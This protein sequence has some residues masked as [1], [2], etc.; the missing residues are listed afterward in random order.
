MSIWLNSGLRLV[1]LLSVLCVIIYLSITPA[2][3][4]IISNHSSKLVRFGATEEKTETQRSDPWGPLVTGGTL[5][6]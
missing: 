2:C 5:S 6:P 3:K 4:D 1:S